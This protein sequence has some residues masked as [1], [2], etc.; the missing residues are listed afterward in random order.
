MRGIPLSQ[1]AINIFSDGHLHEKN[2]KE[3]L[4]QSAY[5]LEEYKGK[6]QRLVICDIAGVTMTGEIDGLIVDPEGNTFL[7]EIKSI[8]TMGFDRVVE[9]NA[10]QDNHIHQANLYLHGLQLA[11][12]TINKGIILYKDKNNGKLADFIISYDKAMAEEDIAEFRRIDGMIQSKT[13]PPRPYEYSS[14]QC[15]YCS[16]GP[17]LSGSSI[18]WENYAGELQTREAENLLSGD[19][20]IA[21]NLSCADYVE[22]NENIKRLEVRKDV[23]KAA[24]KSKLDEHGALSVMT[25]V[26]R[27]KLTISER[28]TINRELLTPD[29]IA[30]ASKKSVVETLRVN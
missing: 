8:N 9:N 17:D 11:G 24:I 21:F 12:E 13:L 27:A 7:L 18:C 15:R 14:W 10:S 25:A 1:R 28:I 20:A 6:E 3:L 30:K 5:R 22:I 26:H 29:E 19:E 2:I 16:F 23:V 4:S